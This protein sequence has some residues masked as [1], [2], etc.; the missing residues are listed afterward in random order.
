MLL[1]V[2]KLLHAQIKVMVPVVN[3]GALGLLLWLSSPADPVQPPMNG[4]IP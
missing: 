4:T 3:D 1:L 2:T